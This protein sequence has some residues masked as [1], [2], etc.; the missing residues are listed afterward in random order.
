MCFVQPGC[1]TRRLRGPDRRTK[2]E[3]FPK[4]FVIRDG[5]TPR[6]SLRIPQDLSVQTI[7]A[8]YSFYVKLLSPALGEVDLPSADAGVE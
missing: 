6:A 5:P 7:F 1:T 2:G 3:A 8:F 4:D